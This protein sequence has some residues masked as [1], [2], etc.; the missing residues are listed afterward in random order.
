MTHARANDRGQ[1]PQLQCHRRGGRQPCAATA[2]LPRLARTCGGNQVPALTQAGFRCIAPD[3]RGFGESDKPQDVEAYTFD[4]LL[5]DVA[6]VLDAA[7]VERA[8]VVGHDWGAAVAWAL[9]GLMPQRVDRLVILS[10]PHPGALWTSV[11]QYEKSWYML[12]FQNAF[13]EEVL[14]RDDWSL[15]RQWLHGTADTD[16]YIAQLS[17]PGALTGGLNWYRASA[18]PEALF[19]VGEQFP[20]PPVTAPTL[21]IWSD[22]D[23]Y[24]TEGGFERTGQLVSDWRYERIEGCDHWIPTGA[25]ER[26]NELLLGFLKQ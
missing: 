23:A 18:R 6:G 11:E 16:R 1:R 20:W 3:Q 10:V 14:M 2:W 19:G 17:R 9:A 12:F 5:G 4:K 15:M 24:L 13:A 25:P 22:G 8:H 21:G 7:G 26:L